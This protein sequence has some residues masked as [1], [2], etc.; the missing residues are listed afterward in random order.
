MGLLF[1]I[2]KRLYLIGSR[3]IQNSLIN[4]PYYE[5]NVLLVWLANFSIVIAIVGGFGIVLYMLVWTVSLAI[6]LDALLIA[7]WLAWN[8]EQLSNSL[9]SFVQEMY[10]ICSTLGYI[11]IFGTLIQL[12]RLQWADG[13]TL[14]VYWLF[15]LILGFILWR[16]TVFNVAKAAGGKTVLAIRKIEYKHKFYLTKI[17]KEIPKENQA[18]AYLKQMK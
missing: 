4:D 7:Y 6:F 1:R 3:I 16:V 18:Q 5:Y 2:L 11:V 14:L 17:P 13:K 12:H 10:L 9:T 15:L 8:W